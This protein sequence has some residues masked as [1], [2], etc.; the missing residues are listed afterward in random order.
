MSASATLRVSRLRLIAQQLYKL[1]R[2][3]IHQTKKLKKQQQQQQ[4]LLSTLCVLSGKYNR[5]C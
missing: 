4:R 1:N 3:A 2:Q 5:C